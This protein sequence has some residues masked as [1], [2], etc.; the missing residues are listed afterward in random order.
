MDVFGAERGRADPETG[1]R[2][3]GS[4]AHTGDC[5][6][7]PGGLLHFHPPAPQSPQS[8]IPPLLPLHSSRICSHGS[9]GCVCMHMYARL[10]TRVSHRCPPSRRLPSRGDAWAPPVNSAAFIC[11]D[12]WRA[13][14]S[15]PLPA[16]S[17]GSLEPHRFAR[18]L[19]PSLSPACFLSTHTH[20]HTMYPPPNDAGLAYS[21]NKRTLK[22]P[23]SPANP[24][25]LFPGFFS[26]AAPRLSEIFIRAPF[27]PFSRKH[28]RNHTSL[29]PWLMP[30]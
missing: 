25:S 6:S 10:L 23:R 21:S 8:W 18:P 19:S 17:S 28:K 2:V 15:V 9:S 16:I 13:A 5:T 24:S 12:E 1:A 4:G 14:L 29:P 27:G 20:T 3:A 26:V 7:A 22:L 11:P 30:K